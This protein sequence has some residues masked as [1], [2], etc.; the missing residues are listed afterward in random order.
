[1]LAATSL[2]LVTL[3]TGTL[4]TYGEV[5]TAQAYAQQQATL[6]HWLIQHDDTRIY[7]DYWTCIRTVFQSN[8]QVICSVVGPQFEQKPNR[9]PPYD[10][11]VAASPNPAY[12]FQLASAQTNTFPDYAAQQ[13]W[14]Y[15]RSTV[16]GQF[17]VFRVLST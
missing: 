7:S 17:V 10:A 16:D 14:T 4:A 6:V 11:V 12:V 5:A 8:E 1:M 13:G 3:A 15:S 9:Y 2:L